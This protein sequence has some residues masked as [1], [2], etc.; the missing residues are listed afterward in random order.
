MRVLVICPERHVI[1]LS[2]NCLFVML[3]QVLGLDLGCY[4]LLLK[5]QSYK[6][7]SDL[8]VDLKYKGTLHNA[9]TKISTYLCC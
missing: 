6:D 4:F 5:E 7:T 1:S 2:V 8:E 9:C 3:G